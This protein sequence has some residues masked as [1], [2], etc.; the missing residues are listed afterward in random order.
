MK[1]KWMK[2]GV[3]AA[4]LFVVAG[5]SFGAVTTV[6]ASDSWLGSRIAATGIMGG[7]R[8]GEFGPRAGAPAT[9]AKALGISDSDLTTALQSGKSVADVAKEKG[10][11]LSKVVDA[12]VAEQ[13]TA[14]KQAVTAGRITQQQADDRIAKLKTDLPTM[15]STKMPARP[16]GGQR[17]GMGAFGSMA[18]IATT[19]GIS[20]TTLMTELQ[21]GKSVADVAKEKSVELSKVVDAIVAEQTTALKKA[22]TDG[23][24]TQ[25]QADDRIAKLKSD[26]PTMLS[27][28]HAAGDKGPGGHFRG[29][30]AG[31]PGTQNPQSPLPPGGT[32]QSDEPDPIAIPAQSA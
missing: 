29:R 32:Q 16:Q 24:L 18:T 3:G 19:L 21:S 17:G 27:M 25:Q 31:Q 4:A 15:L 22:V 7:P 26:L 1:N 5:L 10:V 28:K 12:V 13:T 8:G 20:E 2:L 23:R 6:Q 11:D 9:I 14:L 30:G